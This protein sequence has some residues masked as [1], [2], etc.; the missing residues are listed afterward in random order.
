[1]L[2]IGKHLAQLVVAAGQ[3]QV[4][5]HAL[6]ICVADA[7]VELAEI[8]WIRLIG[9]WKSL[10][11]IFGGAERVAANVCKLLRGARI[12]EFPEGCIVHRREAHQGIAHPQVGRVTGARSGRKMVHIGNAQETGRFRFRSRE[13]AHL[14]LEGCDVAGDAK[15]PAPCLDWREADDH[16][17]ATIPVRGQQ[18]CP[19]AW[20]AEFRAQLNGFV[21]FGVRRKISRA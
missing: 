17:L 20:R 19:V 16:A 13:L 3:Q 11:G 2:P 18:K 4:H 6:L 8:A 10:G 5:G 15:I 12:D 7:L 9:H 14:A 1:M 21:R